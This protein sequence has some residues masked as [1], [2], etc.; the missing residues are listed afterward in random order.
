MGQASWELRAERLLPVCPRSRWRG[1]ANLSAPG[2]PPRTHPPTHSHPQLRGIVATFRMT[3]RAA[4]SRP[5]H[6]VAMILQP[7]QAF[8]QARAG[9]RAGACARD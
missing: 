5:S 7:L 1:A 2:C 8:L 6:Y 3:A 4:P 9:S